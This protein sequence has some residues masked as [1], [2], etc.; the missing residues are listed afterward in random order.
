MTRYFAHITASGPVRASQF[1]FAISV[2][3]A[4]DN[5]RTIGMATAIGRTAEGL[6]VWKL[7][8]H[9][10]GVPARWLIVDREFRRPRGP[11]VI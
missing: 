9:G 5:F 4:A 10:T 1:P 7:W 3:A 6:A 8:V 2:L 11:S